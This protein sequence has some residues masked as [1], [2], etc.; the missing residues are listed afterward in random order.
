MEALARPLGT[1]RR[2]QVHRHDIRLVLD[3]LFLQLCIFDRN[4]FIYL[5]LKS[6]GMQSAVV[7]VPCSARARSQQF[8]LFDRSAGDRPSD[9]ILQIIYA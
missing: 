1:A 9:R 8:D 4:D 3:H 6:A 2:L 5:L 7:Y